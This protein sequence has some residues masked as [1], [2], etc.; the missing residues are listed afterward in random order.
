[1]TGITFTRRRLLGLALAAIVAGVGMVWFYQPD[2]QLRRTWDGLLETVEARNTA[3]LGRV[4]AEDYRDRWGHSRRS[5]LEDARIAF[6][7][8]HHLELTAEQVR[9]V[10]NRNNATVT[11]ILRLDADGGGQVGEAR[12]AI[13]A[14]FTP[15]VFTWRREPGF[16]GAWKL[17]SFDHLELDLAQFRARGW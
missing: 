4:L 16:A 11:A 12:T 6:F 5:I 8:F 10:R 2:R 17:T 14:L 15:F 13:N 1:M 9:V 7:Q 3:R